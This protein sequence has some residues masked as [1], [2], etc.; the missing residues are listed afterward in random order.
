VVLFNAH[1][2]KNYTYSRPEE[3]DWLKQKFYSNSHYTAKLD[4]L[5]KL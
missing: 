5:S 3:I 1:S 2:L 4:Y